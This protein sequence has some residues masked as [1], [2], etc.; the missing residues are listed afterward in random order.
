MRTERLLPNPDKS[1]Y[2]KECFRE[3]SPMNITIKVLNEILAKINSA[4]SK[5]DNMLLPS[6]DYSGN[7]KISVIHHFKRIL[8]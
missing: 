6:S 3:M 5:K 1:T 8:F 2:S 4:T 7:I